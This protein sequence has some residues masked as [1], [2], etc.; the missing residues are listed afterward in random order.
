MLVR[1][2]YNRRIGLGVEAVT[3]I[4]QGTQVLYYDGNVWSTVKAHQHGQGRQ[5]HFRTI[6]GTGC[7]IDGSY[8]ILFPDEPNP[9]LSRIYQV[10]C[11]IMSLTN[12]SEGYK[13]PNCMVHYDENDPRQYVNGE[14]L[15]TTAWLI[16]TRDINPGEEIIWNYLVR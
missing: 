1:I 11:G 2:C 10:P 6:R 8:D 5:S 12:S 14:W 13:P 4:P 15:N 7:T 3:M 9:N 16:T